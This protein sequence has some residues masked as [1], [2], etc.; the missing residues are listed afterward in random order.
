MASI[1]AHSLLYVLTLCI[2]IS[3]W[4]LAG[5]FRKPIEATLFGFIPVPLII[6]NQNRPLHDILEQTHLIL[7]YLLLALIVVHVAA[8]LHHHFY[9]K[10]DILR[11]MWW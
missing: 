2:S 10:N 1:S 3:G 5:T 9:R 7:S 6:N 8:A 4:L 11:R